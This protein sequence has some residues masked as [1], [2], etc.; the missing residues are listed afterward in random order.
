M[1]PSS[2]AATRVTVPHSLALPALLR[3]G[4][5]LSIVPASLA[6]ALA[7][8][9]E[10]LVRTPP[11][12]AGTATTRAVWHRRNDHDPA[13]AWLREAVAASATHARG[14]L[15]DPEQRGVGSPARPR[16]SC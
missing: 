16:G 15:P 3:H 1:A 4:D 2:Q 13:H 14:G 8:S 10:L 6:R 5:M 11:Y 12:A 9:G 7:R